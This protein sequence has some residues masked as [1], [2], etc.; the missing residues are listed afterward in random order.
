[1]FNFKETES[2]KESSYLKPGVYTVKITKGEFGTSK[3]N[4][5]PYVA[6]TFSTE[7]GLALTENFMITEKS[8]SR[9]QYLHENWANKKLDKV[10]KSAQ[11]VAEY[12][13]KLFTNPKSPA[14]KIIVGGEINGKVT[15]ASL[16]YTGFIV[17]ATSDL[18]EG[19]FEEGDDNWNK[20]T[21]K[22][23]RVTEAT[24]KKNGLLNEDDDDNEQ[25]EKPKTKKETGK[26]TE[27]VTK[28]A[29]ESEDEDTPW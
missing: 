18:E 21:K 29:A 15:Y 3:T 7:T 9:L 12:F 14:K 4:S 5:T 22:S 1:M 6:L 26:G 2:A 11:E 23:N 28:K 20:Y 25:E 10:F 16:P 19:E 8:I 27:K 24:G 17:G 13:I